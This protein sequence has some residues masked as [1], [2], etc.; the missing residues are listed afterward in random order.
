MAYRRERGDLRSEYDR[1]QRDRYIHGKM[2]PY[3]GVNFAPRKTFFERPGEGFSREFD[4]AD[5]R[6]YHDE[7]PRN[8]HAEVPRNYYAD[9]INFGNERRNGPLLRRED[10]D[11]RRPIEDYHG[12]RMV[13]FREDRDFRRKGSYPHPHMRERSPV[14]KEIPSFR[15]SPS[16][17]RESPHSRSGS[18]LSNRSYSPE[19]KKSYSYQAQQKKNKERPS[20]YSLNTSRDASPQSSTSASKDDL[21]VFEGEQEEHQPSRDD[22]TTFLNDDFQERRAIAIAE[23]AREIEQVYRQDCKTFGMVV[24]MLVAKDPTLEKQLQT[25]LKEN[26]IEIRERCLEDLQQFIS[27]IDE[28]ILQQQ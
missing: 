5:P 28:E 26:L 25:P 21:Q 15:N 9:S 27:Q 17:R 8:Y 23:K 10:P 19:K 2:G 22:T 6:I 1:A 24:K 7:G 18:S 14:Q 13:E 4:Y 12:S 20:S 11:Y 3:Q 16:S